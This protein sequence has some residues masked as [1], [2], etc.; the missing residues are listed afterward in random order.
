MKYWRRKLIIQELNI[1]HCFEFIIK[2]FIKKNNLT[3]NEEIRL[4]R[5]KVHN[6]LYWYKHFNNNQIEITNIEELVS[7]ILKQ[8]PYKEEE[9]FIYDVFDY[10]T[11]FLK[12]IGYF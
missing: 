8:L 5:I 1:H 9:P 2:L 7:N 3:E 4:L 10:E 11:E 6:I 12:F